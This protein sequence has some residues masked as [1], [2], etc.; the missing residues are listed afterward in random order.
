MT[1]SHLILRTVAFHAHSH[2]L[3]LLGLAVAAAVITG[4][5]VIGDSVRGSLR[6]TALARIGRVDAAVVG[7]G[8][9]VRDVLAARLGETLG[10]DTRVAPVLQLRGLAAN[11]QHR[12]NAIQVCGVDERF[13]RLSPEASALALKAGEVALNQPLAVALGAKSGDSILLRAE[14]PGFL[15]RDAPLSSTSDT[16]V[17][18]RLT[19]VVV[20]D[21]ASFGRFS[22]AAAQVPTPTAFVDLRAL[23]TKAG[24]GAIANL[25]LARG[26]TAPG[27][28][29]AL[30]DCWS[31]ADA[32]IDVREVAG[33]TEVRAERIFLDP[34]LG[35]I[36]L[37]EPEA[38]G[39]ISYFVNEL[40]VGDKTVP[41]SLVAAG[42]WAKFPEHGAPL[43]ES[44]NEAG[45]ESEKQ[46]PPIVI[47]EWLAKDL[48][49]RVGDRLT[50][51]YF[52]IGPSGGLAETKSLFIISAVV[53]M[54]GAAADRELMPRFPGISDA[55]NCKDWHPGVPIDLGRIRPVDEEYWKQHR[56]TP[57]AFI[58]LGEGQRIWGNRFGNL[59]AVRLPATPAVVTEHL[60][61]ALKPGD[62]GLAALPVRAL[63]LAAS[64]KAMNFSGLFVG[65]GFFVV[66]A[67][68]ILAGLLVTLGL[69]RR[70]AEIGVLLAV[71]LRPAL[72]GRLLLGESAVIALIG[73]LI[74][75]ALGVGYAM[76]VLS[77]LAGGWSAAV[78]DAPVRL[79]LLPA[80]LI[81]GILASALVATLVLRWKLRRLHREPIPQ[82]LAGRGGEQAV[83]V[84]RRWPI[85]VTWHA[86]VGCVIIAGSTQSPGAFF[87]VGVLA[88][89]AGVTFAM[90]IIDRRLVRGLGSLTLGSLAVANAARGRG[91]SVAVVTMLAAACFLV[92]AVG[93]NRS[94]PLA[95]ADKRASGTGGFVLVL[96]T[97]VPLPEDLNA[98][99]DRERLGIEGMDGVRFT[100]IRVG[101]GDDAS[102][103][104][105]NHS[106]TPRL[107]GIDPS[108]F[109]GRFT[110]DAAKVML[111][112]K[113]LN[114]SLPD[115]AVP[116]I[117]DVNT[118]MWALGL[119]IG[120]SLTY[121]DE[122]GRP[123]TITLVGTVA[124]SLLQGGLFISEQ[125]FTKHFPSQGGHRQWLIDASASRTG[126]VATEL[127]RALTDY[128]AVATP[129]P[130]RLASYL[131]VERAYL[132]IFLTLGGCAL[133][134]G[135]VGVGVVVARNVAERRG[136]LAAARAIGFTRG[137]LLRLLIAEHALLLIVGL[138]IGAG[139]G[140]L[141][142]WP[143]LTALGTP[144]PWR[145]LVAAFHFI[146]FSGLA[147]IAFA[148]RRALTGTTVNALRRE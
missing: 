132:D 17:V 98:P 105:L 12:A 43:P 59:T 57:K 129:A 14:K 81:A 80:T 116:A 5:L 123:F 8:R 77:A 90:A 51:R 99:A 46:T 88:L 84:R 142:V 78:G 64:D 60:R 114:H 148:T 49:A 96:D 91:R 66:I 141:A 27:L 3:A 61:A 131:A 83:V 73:S 126:A 134:L 47:N 145:D 31:P 128:G 16:T 140:V 120:D 76:A 104:N 147:W 65:L 139:A 110:F 112:W 127:G 11:G 101:H 18:L 92:V 117:G 87:G 124:H 82:L 35:E 13:W 15:P 48:S 58:G 37:K 143:A 24:M 79:H 63:A 52:V 21:D 50:M 38:A 130:A 40:K 42:A 102:C 75:G 30:A 125:H 106:A 72:V 45:A 113:L 9:F 97:S 62:L 55:E 6:D 137:A 119:S 133:L 36:L 121:R 115:E 108:A 34:A 25:L 22:L 26:A 53:P 23:Q 118:T 28:E 144:V 107:F 89:I 146:L 29:A 135:S 85:W 74:G 103:L 138:V 70:R 71:G 44:L 111:G 95:N 41:Y 54:S 2:L 94:D 10:A 19:V 109:A 68:L 86:M 4:S 1:L 93:A 100:A 20:L 7:N 32:L 33:R 39:V 122:Q 56:G 67:A 69:E 136:E